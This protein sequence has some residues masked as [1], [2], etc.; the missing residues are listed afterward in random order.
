MNKNMLNLLKI[1]SKKCIRWRT[2]IGWRN[3]VMMIYL[4]R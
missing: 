1:E 3:L 2:T 4:E